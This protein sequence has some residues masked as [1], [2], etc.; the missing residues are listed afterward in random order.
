MKSYNSY[1]GK[2][3]KWKQILS[4][5]AESDRPLSPKEI[6]S[7][8][9]INHSTVRVYLRR[10]LGQGEV[11]QPIHG[12]YVTKT[13]LGVGLGFGVRVHGLCLVVDAGFLRD[14]A[15]VGDVVESV[16]DVCF[17][18][19]FGRENGKVSGFISCE[20]PGL[21]YNGF[22][23]V[24]DRF[25]QIVYDKIGFRPSEF[26]T[27]NA[28]F[29]EDYLGVQLDGLKS[30]TVR[31]FMGNM[32][33]IYNKGP[34]L[35]SEVK[36]PTEKMDIESVYTLLKG[37]TTPYT[38]LQTQFALLKEVRNLYE[39]IKEMNRGFHRL[40]NMMEKRR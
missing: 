12:Y 17:E 35:R 13:S 21:D 40:L 24:M 18:V 30:V 39:G 8:A 2:L 15:K 36:L 7:S 32:E 27:V 28:E 26:E 31:D 10:M 20:P 37:G 5:L 9:K 29:N 25:F 4:L 23:F 38:I 34:G 11:T 33:R 1:G 16:G 14:Q 22:C 6:A 3:S 19:R